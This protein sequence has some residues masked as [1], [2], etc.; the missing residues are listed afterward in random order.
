MVNDWM[1]S[2]AHRANIVNPEL[3]SLGCAARTTLSWKGRQ[4]QIYVVQVFF[5]PR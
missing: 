3:T 2:P 5:T 1:N 4:E